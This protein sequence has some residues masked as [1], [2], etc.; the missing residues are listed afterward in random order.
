MEFIKDEESSLLVVAMF[1]RKKKQVNG[2]C[3]FMVESWEEERKKV[4]GWR[5]S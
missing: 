2:Y 5:V 3:G 4:R 1:K